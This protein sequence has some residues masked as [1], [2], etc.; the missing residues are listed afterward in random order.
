MVA[1]MKAHPHIA[2]RSLQHDDGSSEPGWFVAGLR[3]PTGE[4]SYHLPDSVWPLLDGSG[5]STLDRAPKWDGHTSTD[6]LARL[7]RW[8]EAPASSTSNPPPDH[9]APR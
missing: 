6:V 3:L 5:V 4:I 8:L 9:A 2:W 1:L 7:R